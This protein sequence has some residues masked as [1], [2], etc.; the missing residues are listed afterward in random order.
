MFAANKG[1][2][3]I[4]QSLLGYDG[5]EV[6]HANNGGETALMRASRSGH[7]EVVQSLLGYDGINVNHTNVS[8]Y[9]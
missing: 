9:H 8:I 7:I 3:D 6:N 4:V 1:H 5:L 2:T